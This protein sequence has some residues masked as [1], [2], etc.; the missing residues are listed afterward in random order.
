MRRCSAFFSRS[1]ARCCWSRYP[2]YLISVSTDLSSLRISEESFTRGGTGDT[3]E[4]LSKNSGK[5]FL[6]TGASCSMMISGRFS[7]CASGWPIAGDRS[8]ATQ[9]VRTAAPG[10]PVERSSH[11]LSSA[12]P[13][14]PP[15]LPPLQRLLHF[16]QPSLLPL[17]LRPR[18][19]R[20]QS[21]PTSMRSQPPVGVVDPQVQTEFRPRSEH[22][23]RLVGPFRKQV[24]NK[25]GRVRF[26]AVEHQRRLFLHFQRR[27]DSG[28]DS[29]AGCFF[30]S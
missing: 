4:I 24:V 8:M 16:L 17:E 19:I 11:R 26:R 15:P 13:P 1:M 6:R 14:R 25:N 27:V 18:F 9:H 28:H 3:G 23:V 22:A 29:L 21:H 2:A 20:D 7:S 10:C 5:R 30:V 12:I